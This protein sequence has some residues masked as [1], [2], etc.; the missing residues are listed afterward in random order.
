MIAR[1]LITESIPPLKSSDSGEHAILFMQEFKVKHL[2]IVDGIE[3]IGL[4]S[5]DDIIDYNQPSA[6][7]KEHKLNLSKHFVVDTQ[8]YYEVIKAVSEEYLTLVPVIT[9]ERNYIGVI[10]LKDMVKYLAELNSIKDPGAIITLELGLHDYALSEIAR[11]VES[12]DSIILSVNVNNIKH[13]SNIVVTLKVNTS[14]TRR[15]IA[16]FE[17]FSYNVTNSF[18][19]EAYLDSFKERYDSLMKYLDL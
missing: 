10:T 14:D 17:R 15:L 2:P 5:E 16:T 12:N 4:I 19:A 3:F 8:H 1:E 9:Q 13:S 18:L 7:L 6:S 11:I